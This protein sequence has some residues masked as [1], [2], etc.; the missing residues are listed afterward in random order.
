MP[1]FEVLRFFSVIQIVPAMISFK[2][3]NIYY[4]MGNNPTEKNNILRK[5]LLVATEWLMRYLEVVISDKM[6]RDEY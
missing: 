2:Q 5:V 3:Q 1:C 4:T 6:H